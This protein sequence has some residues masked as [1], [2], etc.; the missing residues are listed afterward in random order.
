M[1]IKNIIPHK[2]IMIPEIFKD[3]LFLYFTC[4]LTEDELLCFACV[5]HC[6]EYVLKK[7][8]FKKDD[9]S[10]AN[11]IFIDNESITLSENDTC[12]ACVFSILVYH[13]NRIRR[14]N[15]L[16]KTGL[17]FAEEI[18]HFYW[19]I[20]DEN[21]VKYKDLEILKLLNQDY[22]MELLKEWHVHGLR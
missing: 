17:I 6:A 22:S 2:R 9:L 19:R 20:E 15:N 4:E 16:M 8:G 1:N 5:L 3:K 12:Q 14:N 11:V 7:D 10:K 21:D 13:M 18:V